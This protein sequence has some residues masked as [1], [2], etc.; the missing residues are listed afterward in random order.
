METENKSIH[1]EELKSRYS[2]LS[3]EENN[4]LNEILKFH[5][6]KAHIRKPDLV[7]KIVQIIK[8]KIK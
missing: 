3:N 1:L 4:I 7:D 6:K 5:A 2:N 8:G